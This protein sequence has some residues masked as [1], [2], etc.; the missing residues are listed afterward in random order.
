MPE[1]NIQGVDIEDLFA[2]KNVVIVPG[3]QGISANGDL[4]TVGRGGLDLKGFALPHTFRADKCD[5]FTNV[6]D[7]STGD[8]KITQNAKLREQIDFESLLRQCCFD[9]E[10]MQDRSIEFAQKDNIAFTIS[11]T[12]A[13]PTGTSLGGLSKIIRIL[14]CTNNEQGESLS[15]FVPI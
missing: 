15:R 2:E 10:I 6:N 4:I 1:R 11:N 8:L 12:F 14:C 9:N 5:T 13:S 7:V 3:F